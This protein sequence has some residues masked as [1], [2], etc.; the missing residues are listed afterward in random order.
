MRSKEQ[1]RKCHDGGEVRHKG[2][3]TIMTPATK[4]CENCGSVL[5]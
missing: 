1:I 3:F 4:V 5:A 2:P